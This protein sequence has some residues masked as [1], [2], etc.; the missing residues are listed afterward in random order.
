MRYLIQTTEVYRV[1]SESEAKA[2][3]EEA[4]AESVSNLKKY[5]CEYKNQKQ[6]GEIV[7]EWYRVT[8]T[9]AFADEKEPMESVSIN[10]EM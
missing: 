10:Y 4:K 7:Q 3:I 2:L 5:N 9:K 8:L 1:D 6:K